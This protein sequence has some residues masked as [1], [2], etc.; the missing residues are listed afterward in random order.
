MAWHDAAQYSS[1]LHV[2]MYVCLFAACVMLSLSDGTPYYCSAYICYYMCGGQQSIDRVHILSVCLSV[3]LSVLGVIHT[4]VVIIYFFISFF[5]LLIMI[6][7]MIFDSNLYPSFFFLLSPHVP[8]GSRK[9]ASTAMYVRVE[10][11]RV[12]YI[13]SSF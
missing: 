9:A 7:I 5:S 1:C 10:Y 12:Q 2:C 6:M 3:C 8:W 4:Y 13:R 11:S